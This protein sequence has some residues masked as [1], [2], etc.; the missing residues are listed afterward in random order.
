MGF[1]VQLF[2][3]AAEDEVSIFSHIKLEDL[4]YLVTFNVCAVINRTRINCY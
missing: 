2:C 1:L 4:L 3:V